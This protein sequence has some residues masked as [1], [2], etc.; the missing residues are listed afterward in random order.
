[1]R[2]KPERWSI[3]GTQRTITFESAI[4]LREFCTVRI[5]MVKLVYCI[6]KR[7]DLTDEEFFHYWEN[8]HDPIGLGFLDSAGWYKASAW[9]SPE[10]NTS[11][12]RTGMVEL[13]FDDVD[14]LLGARQSPE[15]KASSEDE[16]NFVDHSKVA[17]FVTEEHVIL[18]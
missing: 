14:A 15:W 17:Y 1:M 13:W 5:T 2:F 16:A 7:P 11:L 9:R 18:H 4:E 6:T 10:T 12:I 3:R 8:I